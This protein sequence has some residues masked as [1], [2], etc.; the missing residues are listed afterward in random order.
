M[1]Y[2]TPSL[3]TLATVALA[4]LFASALLAVSRPVEMVVDGERID[5]DVPPVTTSVG[6]IFVPL[7][8]IA[9]ALGAR[10]Q[11][12]EGDGR[13]D[14]VRGNQSLRLK[15]GDTHATVNGMPLTLSHAPFRVRGRV[16]IELNAVA[17]AFNVR[18]KYDPR[19]LRIEV[20]TPGIGQ[21][22]VPKAIL[23][24]Q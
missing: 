14:I 8:S 19:T 22:S 11:P 10:T 23:P 21:A 18:A 9:D 24:T 13:I 5:S 7:R 15:V 16:M 4:A 1:T 6:R 17:G 20:L 12:G 2:R 3:R